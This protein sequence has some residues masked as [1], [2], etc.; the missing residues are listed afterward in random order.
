MYKGCDIIWRYGSPDQSEVLMR[1]CEFST[2]RECDSHCLILKV[3]RGYF[4]NVMSASAY[5]NEVK[6]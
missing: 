2:A 4:R 5:P 3:Q 1:T 6:K